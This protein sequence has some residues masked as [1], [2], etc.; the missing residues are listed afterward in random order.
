MYAVVSFP[1]SD[2]HLAISMPYVNL[3]HRLSEPDG[4]LN[5]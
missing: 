5:N 3:T 2:N 4:M 1:T